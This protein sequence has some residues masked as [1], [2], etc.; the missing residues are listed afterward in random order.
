MIYLVAFLAVLCGVLAYLLGRKPKVVTEVKE[1]EVVREVRIP[2]P[3]STQTPSQKVW[4]DEDVEIRDR[5]LIAMESS[6][7]RVAIESSTTTIV[8]E[9]PDVKGRIIGREGRNLKSFEQVTGVEL[10][11]DDAENTV[12]LS[13]FDPYR[14]EVA[15]QTLKALV[16]DGKIQP[17][18]IEE[19]YQVA[20]K[21]VENSIQQAGENAA[22]RLNLTVSKPISQKLGKLKY[23]TS[24]AQ[25][26]LD[27]SIETA[28]LAT[29]IAEELNLDTEVTKRAALLHDIGKA[30]DADGPHALTGME[31]LKIHGEPELVL[32]AVGAHHHDIEPSSP[33]ARV[34]I[35]ADILSASRPGARREAHDNYIERLQSLEA[36]AN[37]EPGVEKSFAIQAGRELRIILKPE[38]TSDQSLQEIVQRVGERLKAS[39]DHRGQI[40]I[41]TI[42][43][44]RHSETIKL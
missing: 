23:R 24:F 15:C 38:E 7:M 10:M 34:V 29:Q 1:I 43:E 39:S 12:T 37:D 13:C 18:K 2:D 32:N 16:K 9:S 41:I 44:S 28:I 20:T 31:F 19:T 6:A 40:T 30:V 26:V 21:Q 8:L 27:H 35:I 14:R 4:L 3:L 11:I 33:E 5:L 36:I 22:K 42:R 25:N 17:S